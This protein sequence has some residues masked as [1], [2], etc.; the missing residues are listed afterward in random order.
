M[1]DDTRRCKQCGITKP[2]D[3]F[4]LSR[5]YRAHICRYCAYLR[6]IKRVIPLY[7]EAAPPPPANNIDAVIARYRDEMR[8][9]SKADKRRKVGR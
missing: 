5:G 7:E 3:R 9:V 4:K 2:I 6:Y 8:R 1:S